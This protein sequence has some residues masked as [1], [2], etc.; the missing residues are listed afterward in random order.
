MAPNVPVP[1]QR[2]RK[3]VCFDE[4]C[5]KEVELT[6]EEGQ[7]N[8]SCPG[9]GINYG[10]IYTKRVYDSMSQKISAAEE[11]KKEKKSFLDEIF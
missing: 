10:K 6:W 9:C 11:P 8:G 7:Y 4:D 2:N 5:G 3:I 1:K